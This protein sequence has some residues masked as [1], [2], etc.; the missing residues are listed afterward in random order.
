MPT[1][2][3][4]AN[5]ITE[6]SSLF[7]DNNTQ[8]ISPADLRQWIEDGTTSFV[9]QKDKSTL[10][11]SI[12]EAQASTLVAGATVN[13]A[14]ATGNYLHISGTGTINSF[15]TCPAG[16]R[17]I[18]MFEDA[19][20]LTYNATSL[21]IPGGTNKTVV[22]G[23][24]ILILS[25]GSGN[26]RI[27]GY[28]V[29]A[30]IGA[31]TI[32]GVTA[33]TGLS[34]G[35]TSGSVTLNLTNTGVSA[36]SYTN[37]DITVDA[38]G[39]ITAASS[40]SP[41]GVTTVTASTPLASSGGITPNISISKADA[42]TDGYLDNA[43]FATFAGKQDVLSA[44]TGISIL[45]N[46]VTN[47]AP[48]QTVSLASGT[49]IN[50]TGTY[51]SF[52]IAN[53]S[54]SSG[55]T[56]T[57]ITAGTGLNGGTITGS[58]TIDLAN[59]SVTPAA[60]TNANITV[61]A[62]GRITAA[63]NG[64]GGGVSSVATAG[65][66]SGGPI[67]STGT[68]T[69]SMADQKLVGRYAGTTGIMQEITVGSG[70]TLTGAGTL[71][72]TAT[73]TPLGYYGAFQDS[74][75][76]S[77]AAINTAYSVKL[78]TTDLSNN[79]TVVNDGGG[80]PTRV[81]LANA[82]IY[83]IQFSLQLEKTGGSGN[84]IADVWI[85]KNGVDIPS[86]TGKVVLTGSA[87]ASPVIAA[88]NYVLDLSAGDYIQLMWATSNTNV[89][90]V[91]SAAASP[92]P[93]IP[94]VILTVTQ[95]SGIMAGS[96]IT[97]INSLTGAAQTIATGTT[98]T[99]FA[100]VSS[101]TS[102]TLNLPDASDTAR[103]LITTGNQTLKGVKTFGNG[104]S[105]GEI[106]FLEPSGDGT[107]YV[108]LKSQA[109][110]ADYSITLPPA[111]PSGAQYLQSTGVGGVLQWTSGTTTGVSSIGTINSAT[112]NPNGAVISGSNIIMQ[113]ADATNVGLVSIGTQT[114][115]GAKTFSD[116]ATFSVAGNS[117]TAQITFTGSTV[118]WI[119]FGAILG[120][121][122]AITGV[123]GTTR[124][125][126]TKLVLYKNN[127]ATLTDFAIG[128]NGTTAS[129]LWIGS[130]STS[131][132]VSIYGGTTRLAQFTGSGIT[133]GA[134]GSNS[135]AQI[136]INGASFQWINFSAGNI[137][138]PTFT[139]R[140]SGTKLVLYSLVGAND[141]D[142][143]YGMQGSAMWASIPRNNNTFNFFW[144]GGITQI[145]GLRGDGV[146]TLTGTLA[147][148]AGAAAAGSA[149][150]AFTSGTNLTTPV[151]GSMEYNGTNL[152]FTRAGAVREG[153]LTQSAVTT[154][155]LISDTSVTV[156]IGGTTYKLLAKA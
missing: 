140:S 22:G 23:D 126:G 40:G 103:G 150:L 46:T 4:R 124:S 1:N 56:V 58:G 64:T 69:T 48:D 90:I 32:T 156:N 104:T 121:A 92:H 82:G 151:N 91:A 152:F 74:T 86:T 96:G 105:A 52:T 16:A 145:M 154:E 144:Y 93:A 38:Q 60:Y 125:T 53:T 78:N 63:A 12:Y 68:I 98:G 73:P 8:E 24:C 51:P 141:A 136:V 128:L 31:G 83:N 118:R 61:D 28:F 59:T 47:T 50:V 146:L 42:T 62:Q 149:P 77:A 36:T 5:L 75:T 84:M 14:L 108:A 57:S 147:L 115:A 71:N 41:G 95:Q 79:V 129:E 11:N 111:A 81:T 10:E 44:G 2:Y 109:T 27:V 20:T 135:A 25:E 116:A 54:P 113:T 114:F 7:P 119:D 122:P 33:G 97:S 153:V 123:S 89:E 131:S 43:D 80:N 132:N 17:F 127:S 133:L 117:N 112:K 101:G 148:R 106:R 110:T 130:E 65:L 19:A 18:I 29:G 137:N 139:N 72:N 100:V 37:A 30:G 67:T 88:W 76:Q 155:F 39:R 13:L 35:G 15:G 55:G 6:S 9:T 107:N 26:W 138:A 87:N 94:S 134:A 66:I 34:G 142:Y 143:A 120:N 45:S 99:D 49:G 21:I 102:H 85:R 70:L 3:N